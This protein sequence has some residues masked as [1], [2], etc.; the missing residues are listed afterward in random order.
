L[1][2]Q[3]IEV[4]P[5]EI[6]VIHIDPQDYDRTGA[7]VQILNEEGVEIMYDRIG[8]IISQKL[9]LHKKIIDTNYAFL[10]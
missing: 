5:E 8:T 9:V 3:E 10:E 1:S 4:I 7:H 6:K 2:T